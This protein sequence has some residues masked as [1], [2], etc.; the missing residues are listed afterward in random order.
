MAVLKP[1]EW[2]EV[3][4]YPEQSEKRYKYR[5]CGHVKKIR[6]NHY[7]PCWSWGRV[8]TCPD[9]PPY[10]KYPEFGGQTI[11]DCLDSPPEQEVTA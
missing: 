2:P 1:E 4:V 3:E 10:A 6:T 7:G 11:W 8:N 5:R 9:C